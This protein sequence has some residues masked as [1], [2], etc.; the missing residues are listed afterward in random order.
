[1]RE[2]QDQSLAAL[3]S[4]MRPTL[5]PG[6]FVFVTV[7]DRAALGTAVP[8][9]TVAEAEGLSAVLARPDAEALGLPFELSCAW[10][11]LEVHSALDAVGLTAAA[12][13]AL[14]RASISCNA[15]AGYHHDHLLVPEDA[16]AAALAILADLE[17]TSGRQP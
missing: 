14:A 3:L 5:R 12:S 15:I 6:S 10:I 1:M 2:Q 17:A 8:L 9:A 13:S 11:T 16:A 4:G 7:P